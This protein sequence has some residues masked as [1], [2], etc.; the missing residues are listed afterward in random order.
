[1]ELLGVKLILGE[2]CQQ[3]HNLSMEQEE[4]VTPLY[5]T[6]FIKKENEECDDFRSDFVCCPYLFWNLDAN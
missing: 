2:A 5:Y 6:I 4:L 3:A 1:M